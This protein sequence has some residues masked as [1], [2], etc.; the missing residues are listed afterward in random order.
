MTKITS[1]N[2]LFSNSL[3]CS[4]DFQKHVD[5]TNYLLTFLD[6]SSRKPGLLG[7][8]SWEALQNGLNEEKVYFLSKKNDSS[9]TLREKDLLEK[10]LVYIEMALE[11]IS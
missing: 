11:R 2:P 7:M 5:K 3:N 6:P 4:T 8:V 9:M 1:V 10:M